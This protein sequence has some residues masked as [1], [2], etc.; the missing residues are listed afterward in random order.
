MGNVYYLTDRDDFKI[1]KKTLKFVK[2]RSV[3]QNYYRFIR[4]HVEQSG[5]TQNK[6]NKKP[7]LKLIK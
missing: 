2:V 4:F 6:I 5:K 3:M 1:K 7:F